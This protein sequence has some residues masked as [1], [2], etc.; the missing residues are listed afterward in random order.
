[1]NKENTIK[2]RLLKILSYLAALFLYLGLVWVCQME[3]VIPSN[4]G[5]VGNFIEWFGI[6]YSVML[7]L[8]VVQVSAK[9]HT[10]NALIDKEA[11]A[12]VSLLRY[13]SFMQESESFFR[14]STAVYKYCAF[15]SRSGI[16]SIN[17]RVK[18]NRLY[19][20]IYM[21]VLE[22]LD[23][24]IEQPHIAQEII[25][26]FDEATDTRGDRESLMRVRTRKILWFLI[27]LASM[28][29]LLSF[30]WLNY[31]DVPLFISSLMLY[32][33]SVTVLGILFSAK[34]IDNP[35]TGFWRASFASFRESCDEIRLMRQLAGCQ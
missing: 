4:Q 7:G 22:L 19:K 3:D 16:S 26:S 21:Q 28:I 14:L 34:E 32:G 25:R 13:A 31:D 29:W 18:V 27:I 35:T 17:K 9:Y 2:A 33:T 8:I 5:L 15:M 12:L 10:V 1:M 11:D 6:L 30:F 24:R 20:D 23:K